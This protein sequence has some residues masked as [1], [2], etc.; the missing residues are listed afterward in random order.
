MFGYSIVKASGDSMSP[1]VGNGA[2]LLI[3]R[4][5]H[6]HINDIVHVHHALYGHMVK[7]IVSLH[8]DSTYHIAGDNAA[9]ISVK[10]MGLI[11]STQILGKVSVVINPSSKK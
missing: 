8:T 1:V 5:T 10:Q 4:R 7:R 11:D 2:Y 9:S 6:Y 3:K